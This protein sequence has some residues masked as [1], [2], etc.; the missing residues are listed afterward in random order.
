ML[1]NIVLLENTQCRWFSVF[2]RSCVLSFTPGFR[3]VLEVN[4]KPKTVSTVFSALA[5][6]TVK[7][8]SLYTS[9]RLF[10]GLKPGV[11]KNDF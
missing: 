7:T 3:P 10:T 4:L 6:E 9:E 2:Y 11:N 8:V 1:I 5:T